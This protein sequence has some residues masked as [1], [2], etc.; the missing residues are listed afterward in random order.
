MDFNDQIQSLFDA[1]I[2][3]ILELLRE[4]FGEL[5]ALLDIFQAFGG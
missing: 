2:T 4:N 3:I 5:F 1:I